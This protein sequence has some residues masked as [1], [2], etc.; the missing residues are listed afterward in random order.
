MWGRHARP[1]ECASQIHAG[2]GTCA[3]GT[4]GSA[5]R[6]GHRERETEGGAFPGHA[7]TLDPD[8]PAHGLDEHPA[9]IEADTRTSDG[10]SNVAL[11]AHE[12]VEE[13]ARVARRHPK[14]HI[15]DAHAHHAGGWH[16]LTARA[17]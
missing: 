11:E 1:K 14:P 9:E 17:C 6:R 8:A 15:P 4:S 13:F 5:L 10:S 2:G 3:S 7:R 16:P 12:A